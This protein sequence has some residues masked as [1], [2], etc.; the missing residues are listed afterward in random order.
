ME[1]VV[2]SESFILFQPISV[3]SWPRNFADGFSFVDFLARYTSSAEFSTD[4]GENV[5]SKWLPV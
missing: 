2:A 1:P 5:S 4:L 3:T